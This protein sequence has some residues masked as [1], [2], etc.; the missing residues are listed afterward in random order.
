[1]M[2]ARIPRPGAPVPVTVLYVA[3]DASEHAVLVADTE[4]GFVFPFLEL[5]QALLYRAADQMSPAC[6]AFDVRRVRLNGVRNARK[7][8]T[9]NGL[10]YATPR[11]KETRERDDNQGDAAHFHA[12]LEA[13]MLPLLDLGH[14]PPTAVE[15]NAHQ[16]AYL[17]SQMDALQARIAKC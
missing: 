5:A 10:F 17:Q 14:W 3:P 4:N 12:W 16:L 7:C 2:T 15:I 6:S 11:S 1:M 9:V 13:V 8:I